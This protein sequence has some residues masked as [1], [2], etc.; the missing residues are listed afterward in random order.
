[1]VKSNVKYMISSIQTKDDLS[2]LGILKFTDG[3]RYSRV[4]WQKAD[5]EVFLVIFTF[6]KET[7]NLSKLYFAN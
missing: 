5:F 4:H 6:W 7:K 1:M 2:K 3:R